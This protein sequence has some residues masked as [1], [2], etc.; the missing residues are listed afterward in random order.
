M[1]AGSDRGG[2]GGGGG[3]SRR[4]R[5]QEL[6]R[7]EWRGATAHARRPRSSVLHRNGVWCGRDIVCSTE[8]QPVNS[9][10]MCGEED[11][12]GSC[13]KCIRTC[14]VVCSFH[15]A[16]RVD[17]VAS[18][19]TTMSGLQCGRRFTTSPGQSPPRYYRIVNNE[20]KGCEWSQVEQNPESLS[21]SLLVVGSRRTESVTGVASEDENQEEGDSRPTEV[22]MCLCFSR[23]QAL[24]VIISQQLVEQVHGL[25]RD[26]R[27]CFRRDESRPWLSGVTE[28]HA[29]LVSATQ[30]RRGVCKCAHLRNRF[31]MSVSKWMLY[32]FKYRSKWSVPRTLIIL[33]NWSSLSHPRK[34]CSL[35][36]FWAKRDAIV[37]VSHH[38]D[39]LLTIDANMQPTLHMSRL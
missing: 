21:P 4:S 36:K 26:L 38:N 23:C 5:A 6:A 17:V 35:R 39:T 22:C 37:S 32:F 29:Q 27:L 9:V 12:R 33:S 8:L 1:A 14:L 34:K 10:R 30:N 20:K 11:A 18:R 2:G 13:N 16:S 7:M 31:S 19:R 24:V 28:M 15:P 3:L 25:Q